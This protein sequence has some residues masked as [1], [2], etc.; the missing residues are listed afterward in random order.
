MQKD[1]RFET[2]LEV[3]KVAQRKKK[4]VNVLLDEYDDQV[5]QLLPGDASFI[6]NYCFLNSFFF[7][8]LDQD[9]LSK[10]KP[11]ILICGLS[12]NNQQLLFELSFYDKLKTIGVTF[13]AISYF[14][15][16]TKKITECSQNNVSTIN[17]INESIIRQIRKNQKTDSDLSIVSVPYDLA[18]SS[19]LIFESMN[20][21]I[22]VAQPDY[23]I[24]CV[25]RDHQILNNL[26]KLSLWF[27]NKYNHTIDAVFVSRYSSNRL[28]YL[29]EQYP[30]HSFERIPSKLTDCLIVDRNDSKQMNQLIKSI[31]S[32]LSYPPYIKLIK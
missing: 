2:I 26:E 29:G 11:I 3:F 31:I 14:L 9:V 32:N 27:E 19:V 12:K 22:S 25:S 4:T 28:E 21:L 30:I 1:I 6:L 23:T 16:Q 17:E 15:P 5:L 8:D 18:S 20:R 13:D 10:K 7:E 24:C